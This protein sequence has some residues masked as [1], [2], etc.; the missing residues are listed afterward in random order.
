M[1]EAHGVQKI[2]QGRTELDVE[3][4]QIAAGEI[5]G[6]SGPAGSG[7]HVLLDLLVGRTQPSA[8]QLQVA[9]LEPYR[10][11][12]QLLKKIGVLLPEN[13]LYDRLSARANLLLYC[14]LWGLPTARA[15]E[16][17]AI[18]GLAD[19]ADVPAGRLGHSLA[20]RLA[21]ARAILH[22]PVVL[23]LCKPFAGCDSPTISIFV[24]YLQVF[25]DNGGSALILSDEP[26]EL[27]NL[28]AIV[29]LLQGGQI[30]RSYN[31]REEHRIDV[32][33]KVP[34]RQEGQVVLVNPADILYAATEDGQTVLHTSQGTITSHLTM[35]DLAER[36]VRNGFFRAH[37][38]YLV[39]LQRV[40]A[41]IPYTRDSFTILL[42]DAHTEIPLS[43]TAAK[44]LRD[45]LDY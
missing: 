15:D 25:A 34:A 40:H 18:V 39:N 27:H 16:A 23:I 2:S 33:F 26:S 9:G 45:L 20:R 42:D 10:Q 24:H 28:C 31:P 8:G 19:Q 41:I 11:H 17:L 21:F 4:L 32:S 6:V 14:R 12:E 44:E 36:L 43:K 30:V 37:R 29:H 3:A 13:S 7:K 5:A 1:I 22:R 38:S 35:G